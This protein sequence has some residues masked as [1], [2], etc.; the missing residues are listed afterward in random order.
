LGEDINPQDS[1]IA[2]VPM[3]LWLRLSLL[4]LG[5]TSKHIAVFGG[6]MKSHHISVVPLI[7]GL[8]ERGHKV[9]FVVPN[10]TEHKSY[11][12]KGMGS[13]RMVFLGTE[14]WAF[15]KLF[16]GPEYDFKNV[17]WYK[18]PLVFAK[19]LSS[20]RSTLDVPIFSMHDELGPWLKT[21]GIDAVLLHAASLG[22]TPVVATSGIPWVSFFSLPPLPLF[23]EHDKDRVCRYP[24]Y[25]KPPS[26]AKL[27][28]SLMARVKN[29]MTCRFL[30]GYLFVADREFRAL[31]NAR[32]LSIEGTLQMMTST[33]PLLMLLGGPPLSL[34]MKLGS[35]I[36]VLGVVDRPKPHPIPVDML[37]WLEAARDAG[38]PVMYVSMGTKYELHESTCTKLV[39]LLNEMASS[40]GIRFLWSLR[41]SQQETLRAFLPAQGE[42]MRIEAFT[43]QPEVLQHAAVKIFLSHCGWGGVTDT[44][45]AGVPVLGY[46][47]MQDQFS[48]ARMLEEAGVGVILEEDFSNL[49]DS[50]RLL[51]HDAKFAAASKAAGETLRSYGGLPRALE[52]IEAAAEGTYVKP[53][54]EVHAKMNEVDPFFLE[55]QVFVQWISLAI[56]VGIISLALWT[57]CRCCRCLCRFCR[58]RG[59]TAGEDRA[60]KRQ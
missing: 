22:S 4:V 6:M 43:P 17:P 2:M 37:N 29:H 60:K 46:P 33:P 39:A 59:Q 8:L 56:C 50:T 27:K 31:F 21:G 20:Y 57:C 14:D 55:P 38:A 5:A 24:N 12:P 1:S 45:G 11:F 47:G 44:I 3:L 25:L 51:L 9:S 15:D 26:V 16:N 52:I 28:E 13:A 10:T 19:V 54:A 18:K 23:M 48:N 36:H 30:Q 35:H 53:N 58:S 49:V 7:E 40:I 42:H 41:A 34:N 32:G